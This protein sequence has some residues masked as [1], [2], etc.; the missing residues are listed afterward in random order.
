MTI[1]TVPDITSHNVVVE[2]IEFIRKVLDFGNPGW[3]W[4]DRRLGR[5][6][7]RAVFP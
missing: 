4:T 2:S 6:T 3:G 1:R 7:F 5:G